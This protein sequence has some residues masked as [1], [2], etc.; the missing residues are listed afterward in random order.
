MPSASVARQLLPETV[1]ITGAVVAAHTDA[2]DFESFY[3]AGVM[4]PIIVNEDEALDID[5]K[6]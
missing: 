5:S 4:R 6:E 2:L 3:D 1:R